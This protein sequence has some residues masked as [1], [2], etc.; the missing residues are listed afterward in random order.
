MNKEITV[1]LVEDHTIMRQGLESL[2]NEKPD[3][4]VIGEAAN[5]REGVAKALELQPDLVLMDI[6]MPNMN[7]VEAA[8]RIRKELP[9]TKILILSM[10][11]DQRFIHQ[12]IET[13]ISGYL[14]KDSTGSDIHKAIQAAM[15]GETYLSPSISKKV[16]DSYFAPKKNSS[17][18]E[19]FE[20]LSNREREVFQLIA[21]GN[22]TK[23][24]ADILHISQSTVKTHRTNILEKLGID[25]I[26]QI[27]GYAIHMG[28]VDPEI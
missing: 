24:M 8:K 25:N 11:S 2:L 19:K 21:E 1:L 17:I 13:G 7:G 15:Q 4:R 26:V 3:I 18:E 20:Q 27:I 22:S 16:L 23:Q 5:G 6:A 12:L 9:R 10:Y 28:L 14:L